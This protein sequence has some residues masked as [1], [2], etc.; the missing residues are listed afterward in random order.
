VTDF[1]TKD[2]ARALCAELNAR[3]ARLMADRYWRPRATL[4]INQH[5]EHVI[6]FTRHVNRA[7]KRAGS[8]GTP[9]RL[10]VKTSSRERIL[11][12]WAGYTSD[13]AAQVE[14]M[15]NHQMDLGGVA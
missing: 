13:D 15:P 6:E 14:L 10:L 2:E 12:H 1:L 3:V 8:K 9:H 5:Y 11:A 7:A 4:T